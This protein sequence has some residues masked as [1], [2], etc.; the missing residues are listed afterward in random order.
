MP[1]AAE[2]HRLIRP[3]W[4]A[5]ESP[6][7]LTGNRV[8]LWNCE[9]G[10]TMPVLGLLSADERVRTMRLQGPAATHFAH[11]RLALRRILSGYLKHPAEQIVFHYENNG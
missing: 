10:D 9:L 5:C 2:T 11:A 8:H 4:L 1:T 6:P 7:A 3:E